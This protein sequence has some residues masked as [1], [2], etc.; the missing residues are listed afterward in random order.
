MG[1]TNY[2]WQWKRKAYG[3]RNIDNPWVVPGLMELIYN[4]IPDGGHY[5]SKG[6]ALESR[7]YIVQLVGDR[8]QLEGQE[9]GSLNIRGSEEK[10]YLVNIRESLQIYRDEIRG[11]KMDQA[12][13]MKPELVVAV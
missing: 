8:I 12:R 10:S 9:R 2:Y 4:G 5:V 13:G 6:R 3:S 1:E 11:I 7:G